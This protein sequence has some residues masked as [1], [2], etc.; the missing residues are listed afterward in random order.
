[1]GGRLVRVRGVVQN[2]CVVRPVLPGALG[3]LVRAALPRCGA[4]LAA[5][6]LSLL[7]A[8]AP[9][10]RA[11]L[12]PGLFGGHPP[13]G[14]VLSD[15]QLTLPATGRPRG[16]VLVIHGG[17]WAFT[18]PLMLASEA[19]NVRWFAR[20]GW[21]VDNVDYRP[22]SRSVVDVVAAYDRLRSR[23]TR[24]VI[25]AY[26]ESAG[27]QLA[28]L[29]AASRPD[30]R[31]VISAAGITNLRSV[32][33]SWFLH[34]L[35]EQAF[36]GRL[37]QFSPVRVARDIRGELLCAGSTFDQ[38][39]PERAQLAAIKRARPHTRVMLLAGAPT[40]GGGGF[41]HP[42]NF[43]HASVTVRALRLFRAAVEHLLAHASAPAGAGR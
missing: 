41:S 3:D 23:H 5:A 17:G 39:V 9:P 40:P 27:G 43:V 24:A 11:E 36:P 14:K 26:G 29:L 2:A 12:A 8:G 30:L 42:P 28:L 21:A 22:G 10:A 13:R 20:L 19:K 33:A 25:C 38:V 7:I 15:N 32:P 6:G 31:C 35:A 1:M 4:V 37:W 34:D 16:F 18:G